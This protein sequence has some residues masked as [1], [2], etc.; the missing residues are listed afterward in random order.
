LLVLASKQRQQAL[1]IF[2]AVALE[3]RIELLTTPV[4][5]LTC[6]CMQFSSI[7]IRMIA[8]SSL[9]LAQTIAITLSTLN[10]ACDFVRTRWNLVFLLT[11]DLKHIIAPASNDF[12]SREDRTSSYGIV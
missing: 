9:I 6:V 7:F 11:L 3:I 1:F 2:I 4:Q 8:F 5:G 12:A 10:I